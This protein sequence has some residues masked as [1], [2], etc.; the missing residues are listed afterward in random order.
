MKDKDSRSISFKVPHA[1]DIALAFLAF[2]VEIV[3]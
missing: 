2:A 3:R 1:D